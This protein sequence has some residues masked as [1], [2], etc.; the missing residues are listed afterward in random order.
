MD[1]SDVVMIDEEEERDLEQ[2]PRRSR[3]N[4]RTGNRSRPGLEEVF[5]GVLDKFSPRLRTRSLSTHSMPNITIEGEGEGEEREEEEKRFV[6]FPPGSSLEDYPPLHRRSQVIDL[7]MSKLMD[8]E[9]IE[10]L[11]QIDDSSH[12]INEYLDLIAK[13]TTKAALY[14]TKAKMYKGLNLTF[15]LLIIAISTV[16]AILSAGVEEYHIMILGG[17]I[18]FLQLLYELFSIGKRGIY[19]KHASIRYQQ[20]RRYLLNIMKKGELEDLE[21]ASEQITSQIDDLEI[22]LFSTGYGPSSINVRGGEVE[23]SHEREEK[24]ERMDETEERV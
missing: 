17:A 10:D 3:S 12:T 8:L 13:C 11:E 23:M 24:S 21:R 16:I 4:S 15:G 1:T 2:G 14:K 5:P 6:P 9:D 18:T 19:I 22:N 7:A 20:F